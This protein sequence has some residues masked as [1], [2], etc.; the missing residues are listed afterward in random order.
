MPR[1][2]I[3]CEMIAEGIEVD[4][5]I[6]CLRNIPSEGRNFCCDDAAFGDIGDAADRK[7]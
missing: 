1:H 6:D 3:E 2:V 7:G 4:R 5:F